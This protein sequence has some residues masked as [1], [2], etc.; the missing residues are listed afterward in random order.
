MKILHIF[1]YGIYYFNIN[2]KTKDE[3]YFK[4]M[5][6][7]VYLERSKTNIKGLTFE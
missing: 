7:I 1:D 4:S 2:H 6:E 3:S 5:K